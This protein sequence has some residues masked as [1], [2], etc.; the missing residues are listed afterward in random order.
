MDSCK[1]FCIDPDK[2]TLGNYCPVCLK[3]KCECEIVIESTSAPLGRDTSASGGQGSGCATPQKC[4]IVNGAGLLSCTE[5]GWCE[6][7]EWEF[8]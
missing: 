2:Q 8:G 5:C 3:V 7:E 4:R 6:D 1:K